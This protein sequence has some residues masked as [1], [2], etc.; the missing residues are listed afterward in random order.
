MDCGSIGNILRFMF[1]EGLQDEVL[2]ASILQEVLQALA[3]F[4]EQGQIHRD[5]KAGNI[6]MDGHGNIYLADFGVSSSLRVGKTAKTLTGSP[7]WMAPE[8]IE[9]GNGTGYNFK[10]DIWSFGITA[11]ELAKGVPPLIEHT[12]MKIIILIKE[13][14]PPHLGRDDPFDSS[15]KDLVNSCLQKDPEKRPTAEMLLKKRFFHRAKG[16]EYIREHLVTRLPPLEHMINIPRNS[17][18]I[19][20]RERLNSESDSWD[21]NI[22]SE[23]KST[24]K[25][26]DPLAVI[27]QDEDYQPYDPLDAI[28]EDDD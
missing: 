15:F 10:A 25:T 17:L 1:R 18:L 3:Y 8:V 19:A 9:T 2:L 27:G 28:Q 13:S 14:D 21:F 16:S 6:L 24:S 26:E 12:A 20:N 22:S 5:I 23:C 11:I 4:H 7:C